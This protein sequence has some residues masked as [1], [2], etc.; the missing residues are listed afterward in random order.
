[1]MFY[2]NW[3]MA[4]CA[5]GSSIIGLIIM[6]VIMNGPVVG[7]VDDLLQFACHGGAM[8]MRLGR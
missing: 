1:M 5:I 7:F 4:L 8:G 3:I 2:N 6:M